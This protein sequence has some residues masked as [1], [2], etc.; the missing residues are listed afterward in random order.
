MDSERGLIREIAVTLLGLLGKELTKFEHTLQQY[1]M[2]SFC[3]TIS[4][5][6]EF[7]PKLP[8]RIKL[9][10]VYTSKDWKQLTKK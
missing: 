2:E 5:E 6:L 10:G 7:L 1:E 4:Y 3:T 8:S 9:A